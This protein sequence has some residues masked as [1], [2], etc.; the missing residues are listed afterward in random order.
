MLSHKWLW[1]LESLLIGVV[2]S[3]CFFVPEN[4][5]TARLPFRAARLEEA[6]R[7][8]QGC[9]AGALPAE[10]RIQKVRQWHRGAIVIFEV[11]CP[12]DPGRLQP[13]LLVG[14]SY[15]ERHG[16][17]W[18]SG[19]SNAFGSLDDPKPE[20][21][22]QISSNTGQGRNQREAF[23][24]VYGRTLVADIATV[25]VT[26]ADEEVRQDQ[27]ANGIFAIIVDG[28][29]KGCEFRA[30]RVDRQ[31]IHQ[32]NLQPREQQCQA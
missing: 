30:W 15:V 10:F 1:V 31:L 26:F 32:R 16:N 12:P 7:L 6:V 8:A 2:L 27:V 3:G 14:Y 5:D 11:I 24:I 25:E 23:T 22:V 18:M 9:D 28:K 4:T 21:F 17:I 20:Q 19:P 29:V 13:I